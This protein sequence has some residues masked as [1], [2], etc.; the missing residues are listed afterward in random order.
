MM[1]PAEWGQV[2]VA[3]GATDGVGDDVVGVALAGRAAAPRE[4]AGRVQQG[5][6]GAHP[7]ADLV[8]VHADVV[9]QVDDG[10]HGEVGVGAS[11]PLADLLLEHGPASGLV[12]PDHLQPRTASDV[13]WTNRVVCRRGLGAG[14]RASMAAAASGSASTPTARERRTSRESGSRSAASSSSANRAAIWRASRR[15]P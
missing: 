15:S 1:S 14:R 4:H 3:G 6:S 8:A 2:A 11:A 5:H 12:A 10:H 9:G 13:R 7:V